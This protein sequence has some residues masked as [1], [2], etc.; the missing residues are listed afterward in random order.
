M[1]IQLTDQE[2]AMIRETAVVSSGGNIP[3]G[4]FLG[5]LQIRVEHYLM[6]LITKQQLADDHALI[7]LC[8]TLYA[9]YSVADLHAIADG[10]IELPGEDVPSGQ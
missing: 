2:R 6:G 4:Y 9:R 10:T 7:E 5:Y 3:S 1:G 8:K